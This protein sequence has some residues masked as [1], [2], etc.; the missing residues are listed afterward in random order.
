M[1][2]PLGIAVLGAGTVG[3]AVARELMEHRDRLATRAGGPLRLLCVAERDR[4]RLD[5]VDLP[6]IHVIADAGDAV[7]WPGVD[8]VV[9]LLGGLEPAGTL[10]DA[11]LGSGLGVVT[12][13][14]AVIAHRGHELA[15]RVRH[16]SGGLA[17]E[18]AVGAAIP[19]LGMLRDSLGGDEVRG[20]TAVI[21][22]T[23][24]F[25]LDRLEAGADF[26]GAVAEAQRL[27][28]AEADPAADLDGHDAAQKLCILAWFGL[29]AR[30]S[31]EQVRRRGIRGL[32]SED[33][34]AAAAS[35]AAIRLVAAAARSDAGLSLSVQP[36]LVPR[37]HALG[38]VRGADNLVLVESD[39][40]G[41]L[42]IGGRGAGAGAAASAVLSDLVAVARARREQR[43]VPLPGAAPVP[44]A[45]N[46]EAETSA[47]LRLRVERNPDAPAIVAQMLEDRGVRV[48]RMGRSGSGAELTVET[49]AAPRAVLDRALE[50]L[51]TVPVLEEVEQVLDRLEASR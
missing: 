48:E 32:T 12:A 24:N 50:T 14:K 21:N 44:I 40:A 4:R 35:D 23:T 2:S 46:E 8:V 22:G 51:D 20:I 36:T 34:S 27:G 33:A 39:L 49:G 31:P 5:G 41:T 10:I 19:V 28:Y 29:G 26:A 11:A 30:V 1:T 9:E 37:S 18:A 42:L 45:G 3:S 25:V 43:A 7:G 17:F 16:G 15:G 6:G 38:G 47:W 13:N